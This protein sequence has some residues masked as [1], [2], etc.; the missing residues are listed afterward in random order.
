MGRQCWKVIVLK[1]LDIIRHSGSIMFRLVVIAA[2]NRIEDIDEAVIRRFESKVYVG[3]PNKSNRILLIINFLKNI[4]YCLS[5]A[6]LN[7]IA[8]ITFGWSASDL[9]VRNCVLYGCIW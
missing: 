3:V 4:E 8:D 9:E 7:H 5:D 6:D 2:T 1:F